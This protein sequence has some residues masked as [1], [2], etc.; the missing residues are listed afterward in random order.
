MRKIPVLYCDFKKPVFLKKSFAPDRAEIIS[1]FHKKHVFFV[2]SVRPKSGF[3][4]KIEKRVK[5]ILL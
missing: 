5:G 2:L 3:R 1:V 4:E